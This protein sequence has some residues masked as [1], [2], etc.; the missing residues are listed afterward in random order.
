MVK[1][2]QLPCIIVFVVFF[3]KKK[4]VCVGGGGGGV[5][6]KERICKFYLSERK[7]THISIL[8]LF[9]LKVYPFLFKWF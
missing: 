6:L 8:D 4:C 9:F 5:L 3:L 2:R 7:K 1:D